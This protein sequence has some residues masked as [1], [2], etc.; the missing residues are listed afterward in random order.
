MMNANEP[1]RVVLVT[2][3]EGF[4]G[5][6]IAESFYNAGYEVA[7]LSHAY[8]TRHAFLKSYWS[9][10][11]PT[12]L[13]PLIAAIKPALVVHTASP[14]LVGWSMDNPID[15]FNGSAQSLIKLMDAIRRT[16]PETRVIFLSSAAVYGEPQT[17][18][19]SEAHPVNPLSP[20]GYHKHICELI[21]KEYQHIYNVRSCIVRIFSAYGE[22]LEKQVVWDLIQKFRTKAHVDVFGTGEETRDF[23]HGAD[24][25]KAA[26]VIEKNAYF[27]AEVYNVANGTE[28]SIRHLVNTMVEILGYQ[29]E[30]VY[31]GS[32]RPGD[33]TRWRAD[34][35]KLQDLGFTPSIRLEDGVQSLLASK[36]P[37]WEINS[38]NI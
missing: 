24:V 3:C 35:S 36:D 17:L 10:T 11:L 9:I 37:A 22:G 31:S 5:S 15:D 12:D 19:I 1:S 34:I 6:H 30:I 18:P 33:P 16:S 4:L 32:T 28:T 38:G 8:H 7:G 26:L 23:I 27:E 20:Y 2:G 13:G 21:L 29:G 14:A 25:A